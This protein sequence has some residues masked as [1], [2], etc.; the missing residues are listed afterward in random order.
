[1]DA[2]IIVF[3]AFFVL[4][5]VVALFFLTAISPARGHVAAFLF[6]SFLSWNLMLGSGPNGG[7]GLALLPSL[8][9]VTLLMLKG[10]DQTEDRVLLVVV[11]MQ[12][13]AIYWAAWWR[14]RA[15]SKG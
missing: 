10:L 5:G 4:I 7:F 6:A 15:N 3:N 8:L 14:L 13:T 11:L 2:T 1:M 12:F 9:W